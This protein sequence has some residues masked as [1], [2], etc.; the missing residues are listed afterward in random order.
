MAPGLG[1]PYHQHLFSARLDVTV[2]GTRNAVDELDV[3][4]LPV[5]PDNPYGNAFTRV[6]TR[7]STESEGARH[8]DA[9]VG[10]SWRISN[11]ERLGR[12]G[13]PVGYQLRPEGQSVLLAAPD[14]SVARRAAFATRSLWV[15]RYDPEQRYPAG[16]L[17]NQ[18][19][20]RAGLPEYVAADRPIDGEDIVLWHT[21]GTTHFPRPE[22]WP[23]MPVDRC[24]FTLRPDGFF[25]R[26]P[27]LDVPA[28]TATHCHAAGDESAGNCPGG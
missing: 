2:D 17:V 23:V 24:G 19:P 13:R 12:L 15:T 4:A 7:L 11:P 20:G 1:A 28:S 27:T 5:G 8:A 6:A 3:R 25:D 14:S 22:E 10:R 9:S 16:D 18:H 21:F 26:N